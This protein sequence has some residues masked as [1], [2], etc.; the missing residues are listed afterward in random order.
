MTVTVQ[1]IKD[2]FTE[3]QGLSTTVIER[4]KTQA[5]RRVSVTQW[6]DKADDGVLWLTAHLLKM[7][8][9]R[10][11]GGTVPAGPVSQ[12]KTGDLSET[13][14]IPLGIGRSALAQTSYGQYFLE[15]QSSIFSKRVLGTCCDG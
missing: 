5:E 6:S 10:A 7:H 4:W 9:I 1:D 13:Y 3:F 12:K 14:A 11:S 8:C 15:L 2:H